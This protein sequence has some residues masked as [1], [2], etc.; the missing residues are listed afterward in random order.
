LARA[1]PEDDIIMN[2]AIKEYEKAIELNES[3]AIHY[4]NKGNV[5]LN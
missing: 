2:E 4:F 3:N 1:S 5:Y